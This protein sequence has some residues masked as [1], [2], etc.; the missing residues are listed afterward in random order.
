[1]FT[2]QVSLSKIIKSID[3]NKNIIVEKPL[4]STYDQLIKI[5]KNL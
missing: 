4:C 5:K 1:M 3:N 2:R